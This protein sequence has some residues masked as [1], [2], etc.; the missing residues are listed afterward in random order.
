VLFAAQKGVLSTRVGY[1]GGDSAHP[2][3]EDLENHTECI[4]VEFDATVTSRARSS[5]A[6]AAIRR[7]SAFGAPP[8]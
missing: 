8:A 7:S 4:K 2:T 6:A 1:T 5:L 3:Y